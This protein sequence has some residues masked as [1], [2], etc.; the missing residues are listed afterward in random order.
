MQGCKQ[1]GYMTTCV[2][3]PN[4]PLCVIPLFKKTRRS[5]NDVNPSLMGVYIL[6]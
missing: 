5:S 6:A 4:I 2:L 3:R 1:Q